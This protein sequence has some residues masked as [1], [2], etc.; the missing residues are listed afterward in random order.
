MWLW[1]FAKYSYS[2]HPGHGYLLMN[3]SH[4]GLRLPCS[5]HSH[6]EKR[7]LPWVV[8]L[9]STPLLGPEHQQISVSLLSM[10][11]T[12]QLRAKLR[13]EGQ[14][15]VGLVD[16]RGACGSGQCGSGES[17]YLARTKLSV[18]SQ[19][20]GGGAVL[21]LRLNGTG[22]K[23]CSLL[24]KKGLGDWNGINPFQVA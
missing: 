10:D 17:A 19:Y 2:H 15:S 18:Q 9:V 12:L 13:W 6:C 20:P 3:E 22:T 11:L 21:T 24:P 4:T 1:R 5:M 14:G 7:I 16:V 8:L 23:V